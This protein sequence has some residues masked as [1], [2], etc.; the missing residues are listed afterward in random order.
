MLADALK[1]GGADVLFMGDKE[2]PAVKRIRKLDIKTF[3]LDLFIKSPVRFL[4]NVRSIKHLIEEQKIDMLL[5]VSAP[6]HIAAGLYKWFYGV[7][8]PMVKVCLD[9]VPPVGNIFNKYLHN[10][11]TDYIVFPG[12]ATKKRYEKVF[13]LEKFSVLHAPIDLEDFENFVPDS[14]LKKKMNIPEDKIIVGFIGRFSP[15]KGI[16]FLF[17]IIKYVL[18]KSQN[19]YFLL[20]GSEEQIK[21][22]DVCKNI[23]DSKLHDNLKVMDKADD[24][25]KILAVTDI[26]LLSS[27]YS[28]YI[29]RVAV[30]LMAS[31]KPVVAPDL[32][33][34]PEVV[35]HEKTGFIYDL[36]NYSQAGDFI[37]KLADEENLRKTMGENGY[38]R[39]KNI[40]DISTFKEEF[41]D[42][43]NGI[44]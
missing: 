30:E 5:P 38:T 16:D 26:G 24:V 40:Y 3:D 11:L 2:T 14:D 13:N 7:N 12:N 22:N 9:N 42:I 19:V 10:K 41:F 21:H 8:I 44:L 25:R 43:L 39:V 32:N 1:R 27:R 34:I 37:L 36:N 29:C 33:V 6:G 20:S 17:E 4:G 31:K 15:E 18:Q 28:E 35:I 23:N